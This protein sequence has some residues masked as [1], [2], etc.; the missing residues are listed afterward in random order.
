MN[1]NAT[2]VAAIEPIVPECVP[3]LYGGDAKEYVVFSYFENP[4]N[5]ADDAPQ[6]IR[7]FIQVHWFLPN[8]VNPLEKKKR[9]KKALFSAGFTYPSITNASDELGQHYVFEFEGMEGAD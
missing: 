6:I 9:I 2:I 3:D 7:Y 4:D 8:K 1:M 5:F